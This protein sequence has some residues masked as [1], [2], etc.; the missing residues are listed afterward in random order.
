MTIEGIDSQGVNDE[1]YDFFT[2][3]KGEIHNNNWGSRFVNFLNSD[4]IEGEMVKQ[5][6]FIGNQHYISNNQGIQHKARCYRDVSVSTDIDVKVNKE[7]SRE[8]RS[9]RL[10][11]S[12]KESP[13]SIVSQ[14]VGEAVLIQQV[15]QKN[16]T[17]PADKTF[18]SYPVT[19]VPEKVRDLQGRSKRINQWNISGNQDH[20]GIQIVPYGERCHGE[21]SMS[22]SMDNKGNKE[23]KGEVKIESKDN[24]SEA[25]AKVEV[26]DSKDSK[27]GKPEVKA[28]VKAT[29][30][31]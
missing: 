14:D 31:F 24:K 20:Q 10:T 3:E 13:L 8:I 29:K 18:E 17:K 5:K 9:E 6:K 23:V 27:D 26:K 21:V 11:S 28:E 7:V 15:L 2:L 4:F 12:K 25:S 16:R 22:A 1:N 19:G 30:K